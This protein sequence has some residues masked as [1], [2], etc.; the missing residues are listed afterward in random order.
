[1]PLNCCP[2]SY[3]SHPTAGPRCPSSV[4]ERVRLF[5]GPRVSLVGPTSFSSS[6]AAY[7][8]Y[9]INQFQQALPLYQQLAKLFP[10]KVRFVLQHPKTGSQK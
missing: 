4:S 9:Q 8:H 5:A 3:P 7:C 6:L 1:M 2:S 10:E